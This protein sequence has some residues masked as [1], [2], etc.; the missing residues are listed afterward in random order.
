[1]LN[2]QGTYD[3]KKLIL[4]EK[5]NISSPKKVIVTFIDFPEDEITSEELHL[6]AETGGAF[7]FLKNK[8]EDIYT[9]RDLKVKY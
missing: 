4:R 7:D 1:M 2:I 5:I 8:E 3:G 9:D 6:L